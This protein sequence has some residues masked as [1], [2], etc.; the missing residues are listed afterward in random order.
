M[1]STIDLKLRHADCFKLLAACFYEPDRELF[2][3]ERL[4]ENLVTLFDDCHWQ[5]SATAAADMGKTLLQSSEQELQVE[6][7]QLFVGPFELVAPPYGS[8]YLEKERQL[9]GNST[10][11]VERIYT[12]AGVVLDVQELPDH[13]AL[14]L[15]FMHYLCLEE[16]EAADNGDQERAAILAARQDEFFW[17]FL[18]PWVPTFCEKIRQ[19]TENGFYRGLADCLDNFVAEI[20]L[21]PAIMPAQQESAIANVCRP[22]L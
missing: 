3:A 8:V 7:S 6:Y 12:E 15:E 1:T 4:C 11:A 16:I 21:L 19:G 20:G 13:I 14:E 5:K 22:V 18:A 9:M 17:K 10:I 2:L